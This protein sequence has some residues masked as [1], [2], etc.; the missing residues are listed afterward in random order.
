MSKD[1]DLT[2]PTSDL[3]IGPNYRPWKAAMGARFRSKGLYG[4]I[5]GSWP[6]PATL[7]PAATPE[8][9]VAHTKEVKEQ[10]LAADY[11]NSHFRS[12]LNIRRQVPSRVS[13]HLG[14]AKLGADPCHGL[15]DVS[16]V[17]L[18]SRCHASLAAVT[19]P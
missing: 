5:S 16:A 3:L 6:V 12:K 18:T 4:I 7:A 9:I 14:Y 11:Q 8:E 17:S 10:A 19:F 1:S 13:Q 2:V 15:A